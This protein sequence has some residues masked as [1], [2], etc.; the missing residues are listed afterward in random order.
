[1]A[2]FVRVI[3]DCLYHPE[4]TL[5]A[6]D[7]HLDIGCLSSID[8]IGVLLTLVSAIPPLAWVLLPGPEIFTRPE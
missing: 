3:F 4:M 5:G 8:A 2:G 7:S 1:L 6:W